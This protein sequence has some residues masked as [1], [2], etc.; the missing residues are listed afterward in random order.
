MTS[1]RIRGVIETRK[2]VS[3]SVL[4]AVS[5]LKS[6]KNLKEWLMHAW[7]SEM[8]GQMLCVVEAKCTSSAEMYHLHE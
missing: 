1:S 3:L 6:K 5:S 7:E 8:V 2:V 4:A